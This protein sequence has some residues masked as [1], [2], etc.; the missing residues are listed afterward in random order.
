[1][2][3]SK[4]EL[5]ANGYRADKAEIKPLDR[6]RQELEELTEKFIANGGTVVEVPPHVRLAPEN[7]GRG[8]SRES[9]MKGARAGASTNKTKAVLEPKKPLNVKK[10]GGSGVQNVRL[11]RGKYEC[12]VCNFYV[13]LFETIEEA[14]LARDNYRKE[15]NMRPCY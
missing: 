8:D 14:I 15:Y 6:I 3:I 2:Q 7:I 4:D 13:G 1:M 10:K 12:I 5:L 11:R 9:I